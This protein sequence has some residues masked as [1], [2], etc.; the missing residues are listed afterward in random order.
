M[1]FFRVHILAVMIILI[2]LTGAVRAADTAST[3]TTSLSKKIKTFMKKAAKGGTM[4]VAMGRVAEQKAQ[5]DDVK[6][7]RKT[8]RHRSR[9][10]QR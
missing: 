3:S 6:S 8:N 2:G 5:S 9:Q 4:E 10:S 7:L 1:E